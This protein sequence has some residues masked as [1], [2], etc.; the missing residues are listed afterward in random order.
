MAQTKHH[1]AV[2]VNKDTE[3]YYRY[4][5]PFKKAV[6]VA[7][8]YGY[9]LVQPL[10]P[11]DEIQ[12]TIKE[13]TGEKKRDRTDKVGEWYIDPADKLAEVHEYMHEMKG[14]SQPSMVCHTLHPRRKVGKMRL[15]IF[16]STKTI[17]EGLTIK[18]ALEILREH[19]HEDM[20]IDINSVGTEE[21]RQKFVEEFVT[22]YR[23]NLNDLGSCCQTDFKQD[24]L[25]VTQCDNDPCCALQEQAP[26][27]LSYLS[28]NSRNHLKQCIEFLE[29]MDV[30]Y[31]INNN[32][33][34][35]QH[36]DSHT[37]FQIKKCERDDDGQIV[38]TK[39]LARGERHEHLPKKLGHNQCVPTIS[40]SIDLPGKQHE[41]YKEVSPEDIT[42]P[43]VYY[44]HL[45]MEA[46]RKSLS[47]LE[48]LRKEGIRVIHSL[49]H[50]G[51]S[52]QMEKAKEMKVPYALIMGLKEV[53][54]ESIIVRDMFT[55]AQE[56]VPVENA[57][58]ELA[59]L[60]SA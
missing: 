35:S 51:L 4:K 5:G 50:D 44:L 18:T 6:D 7:N 53:Q 38:N 25:Q 17:A 14:W 15:S 3:S 29:L 34:G 20:C 1:E 28:E 48:Q 58:E 45:G 31:R 24:P 26:Q 46:K 41:S 12:K 36:H 8:H 55:R 23:N 2:L 30:P 60:L 56:T 49:T 39:I 9:K 16:G 32:L 37:I 54:E 19:G 22:H 33:V 43:Q 52:L 42:R 40:A 27:S 59:N 11:T 57:A 47:V 10:E 13:E 21:S